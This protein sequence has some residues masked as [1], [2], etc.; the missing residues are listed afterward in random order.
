MTEWS[1]KNSD[2]FHPLQVAKADFRTG[3]GIDEMVEH[4]LKEHHGDISGLKEQMTKAKF[5][6]KD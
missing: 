6:F 1:E 5:T 2:K 3:K 4:F